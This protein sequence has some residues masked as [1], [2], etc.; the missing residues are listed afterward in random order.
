MKNQ[1]AGFSM[2]STSSAF[3][4]KLRP[5]THFARAA[6][7]H[8]RRAVDD[9]L[10]LSSAIEIAKRLYPDDK[11]V[12]TL[13]TRGAV[14]PATLASSGWAGLVAANAVGDFLDSL[15]PSSAA[16]RLIAAGTN[17]SLDGISSIT[18]PRRSG[19]PT[20]NASWV[21]EGAPIKI[22][23]YT[24]AGGQ[25]GPVRKLAIGAAVTR[26]VATFA[27]GEAVVS[28]LLRED[29]SVSLDTSMFDTTAA[30]TARPAGL[31]NGVTPITATAGGGDEAM[32]ADLQ[33]LSD[34]LTDAG[35]SGAYVFIANNKLATSAALR[36][37]NPDAFTL[38]PSQTLPTGTI[39][40]IDPSGFASGFGAEPEIKASTEATIQF[41]DTAPA[42]IGTVG[43]PN[44]IAAPTR[45]A[46]Q[47][48]LIVL[49][50]LLDAAWT[51]RAPGLVQVINSASWG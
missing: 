3:A 1:P 17:V 40:G 36:L 47:Q 28:T 8:I 38:W 13:L 25:L 4:P 46:F 19:Q 26:E 37:R 6:F 24:L 34:A 44:V 7:S 11:P 16:A 21:V 14:S 15:K 18:F 48:D 12:L 41:E 45:S 43:T 9:P 23:N 31:L 30:S 35:G 2:T 22:V 27:G 42:A 32:I 29:A 5:A 20:N 39:I 33:N 50:C 10:H 51:M 49:R